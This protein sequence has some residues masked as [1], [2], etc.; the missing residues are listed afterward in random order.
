[1]P[2][3]Q[4]EKALHYIV[5]IG[6]PVPEGGLVEQTGAALLA[7]ATMIRLHRPDAVGQDLE[8]AMAARDLCRCH[9]VPFGVVDNIILAKALD[10]DG[11]HFSSTD[12]RVSAVRRVL[13]ADALVGLSLSDLPDPDLFSDGM[14]DYVDVPLTA[15]SRE[16]ACPSF[17]PVVVSGIDRDGVKRCRTDYPASGCVVEAATLQSG[18]LH[19]AS[20]RD[21][22]RSR[23]LRPWQ[24]E[25]SLIED[26]LKAAGSHSVAADGFL[27]VPAGDDACLLHAIDYPVIT[28]DTQR[29]GVHFKFGWQT[30]EEVGEK[31]VAVALSDLAASYAVP[32]S[33]FI[34]LTVPAWMSGESVTDVYQGVAKAL[35]RY[36]CSLGGGNISRGERFAMDLFAVGHGRADLFPVRSAA[37]PGDGVYCTGPLGMARAGLALLR[38][39][40]VSF[41]A[42][43]KRF[44]QPEARFG[45]ADVLYEAAVRCVMDISDGLAGDAGHIARASQVSI[46]LDLSRADVS[47]DFLAY[48]RQNSLSPEEEMVAGGEDYELLF[49]CTPETFAK[50]QPKLKNPFQ[51]GRCLP[52][53]GAYLMNLPPGIASFQHG[54][55]G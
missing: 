45:A 41:P 12:S 34:N 20:G 38:K 54:Q 9:H 47:P 31:A 14:F 22:S 39:G 10:A 53:T 36:R 17:L 19:V 8:G 48:C 24:D 11:V 25:F 55:K 27:K 28:T 32:V 6:G 40:D 42:L 37:L 51:V 50:I 18:R 26:L 2:S 21:V 46:E 16:T 3:F 13:G 52:F 15:V 30:P 49:T 29:E 4:L 7:G 23:L 5:V 33:L 35:G 1:M 44:K 43:V